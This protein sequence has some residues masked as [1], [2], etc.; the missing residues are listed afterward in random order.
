MERQTLLMRKNR[1]MVILLAISVVLG[2]IENLLTSKGLP[3]LIIIAGIGGGFV[4][5]MGWMVYKKKSPH[6]I[7]FLAGIVLQ[8]IVFAFVF[9]TPGVLSYLTIYL[10]LFLIALYQEI[11]V[12]LLSSALSIAT[13]TFGLFVHGSMI[14]P[15]YDHLMG[16]LSFAFIIAL[17]ALLL[18][19]Q[20]KDSQALQSEIATKQS[21]LEKSNKA[22]EGLLNHIALT[23]DRLKTFSLSLKKVVDEA[24]DTSNQMTHSFQEISTSIDQTAHHVLS[25][26][27]EMH[28]N[29]QALETI[30]NTSEDMKNKSDLTLS[31]TIDGQTKMKELN[32]SLSIVE[33]D[34]DHSVK[35][36]EELN[37]AINQI[38]NILQTVTS[39]AEQTNLLALNASIE[40]ARAGEAGRGFA[41]V[42]E[43]IRKLAEESKASNQ[44]ISDIL[45]AIATQT[46]E[47][48]KGI[49]HSQKSIYLSRSNSDLVITSIA[50]I[51]ENT[52]V[53]KS[54][55]SLLE[56][57][58]KKLFASFDEVTNQIETISGISE[59]NTASVETAVSSMEQQQSNID[60]ITE[61]YSELTKVI[62]ELVESIE[63]NRL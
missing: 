2:I 5:L 10:A 60:F 44:T 22:I 45:T 37:V 9:F 28:Q 39:I 3:A 21:Q 50:S 26:N 35:V 34:I 41:V 19:L 14:F 18:S 16:R 29:V 23:V 33:S 49:T 1:L 15:D 52:E 62:H 51:C 48:A 59:E 56:D 25:I 4:L 38:E 17:C 61:K 12:I 47:V 31:L 57:R 42:A 8:V 58:L 13:S 6:A 7:M 55:S 24:H 32:D 46:R 30:E 40:S 27:G 53:I 43:E 20:C 11:K 63:S 54:S 36:M